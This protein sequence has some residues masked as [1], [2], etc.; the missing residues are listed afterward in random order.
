MYTSLL[1]EI[2]FPSCDQSELELISVLDEDDQYATFQSA[3]HFCG[4]AILN[5]VDFLQFG[6]QKWKVVLKS[7]PKGIYSFA[8]FSFSVRKFA[9]VSKIVYD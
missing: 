4:S 3:P 9:A 1:Q 2:N 6:E 7:K 8:A 5:P